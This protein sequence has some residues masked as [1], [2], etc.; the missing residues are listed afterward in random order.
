MQSVLLRHGE[1]NL[2]K[3]FPTSI[4]CHHKIGSFPPKTEVFVLK[5]QNQISSPLWEVER[6]KV[7]EKFK[8]ISK[9]SVREIL[10]AN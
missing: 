6:N 5:N 3:N 9:F 2:Q 10:S 7:Q 8:G 1:K 4:M